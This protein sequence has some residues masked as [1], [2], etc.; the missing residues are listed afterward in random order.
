MVPCTL[1]HWKV[2][3]TLVHCEVFN[4]T[5]VHCKSYVAR[6][7]IL[8]GHRSS[9]YSVDKNKT[10]SKKNPKAQNKANVNHMKGHPL[11]NVKT[12]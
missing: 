12:S 8:L 6:G 2:N 9:F 1:V 3:G 4:G 11:R 5:L 10:T 7:N